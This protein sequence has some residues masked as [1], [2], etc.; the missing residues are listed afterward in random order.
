MT[1]SRRAKSRAVKRKGATKIR[2]INIMISSRNLAA[3]PAGETTTL[4]ELR[5]EI[6]AKLEAATLFGHPLFNVWI[7]E[8]APAATAAAWDECMLRVDQADIL[9]V[10]YDGSA[11]WA[12]G[13]GDM[14]ICHGEFQRAYS[15]TPAKVLV[16]R[17]GSEEDIKSYTSERDQR[18][19]ED[20]NRA[21]RFRGQGNSFED[22]L[23]E[24]EQA[25]AHQVAELVTLAASEGRRNHFHLGEALEWSKLDYRA[26]E[27]R[28]CT[29]LESAIKQNGGEV[30]VPR[31]ATL[32]IDGEKVLFCLHAVP[33][34]MSIGAAREMIGRPFLR[35]HEQIS[36]LKLAVGPVHLIGCNRT[37]TETQAA[38]LLGFPDATIVSA[39]FGIYVADE[40]QKVQFVLLTNCRDD[41]TTRLAL[42][43]LVTWLTQ[44]GEAAAMVTRGASRKRIV[45]AIAA[46]IK[47]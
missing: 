19:Q 43:K 11:G 34:S 28:I 9:L 3:F 15:R 40:V 4:S 29:V 13:A 25:I 47:H 35:D 18:F 42:Q 46:E 21:D 5:R 7:N 20:V 36:A 6:K 44:S 2:P 33:G 1:T 26:R 30:M 24:V 31:N 8:D 23:N 27:E 37:A 45:N 39:P 10:I 17:A 14:G 16:I 41:A 22:V 38:S 32:D 12:A